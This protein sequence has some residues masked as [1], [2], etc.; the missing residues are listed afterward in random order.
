MKIL[1]YSNGFVWAWRV[2]SHRDPKTWEFYDLKIFAE[3]KKISKGKIN[4][5]TTSF[6]GGRKEPDIWMKK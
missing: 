1:C 2:Q 5:E 6:W 3:D 4:N